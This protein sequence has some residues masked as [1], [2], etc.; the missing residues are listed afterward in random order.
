MSDD[1]TDDESEHRN[2]DRRFKTLRRIETGFL[3][4][5][6]AKIWAA[7]ETYPSSAQLS[8]G[9]RSYKCNPQ[10]RSTNK[11]RTPIPGLPVNFY[12]PEWLC[13]APLSFRSTVKGEVA[14]PVLVSHNAFM[15][16]G[17]TNSLSHKVPYDIHKRRENMNRS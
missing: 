1:E 3:T 9:N 8:C 12:H 2:P 4:S 7:V 5:E 17:A 11:K 13:R 6:I 15:L 16:S 10:V 14:L